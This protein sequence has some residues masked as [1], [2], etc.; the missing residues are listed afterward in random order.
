MQDR[1]VRFEE[2]MH[3]TGLARSTVYSYMRKGIFPK[4]KGGLD[5]VAAWRESE[6]QSW[7]ATD[8]W[9]EEKNQ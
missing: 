7:I 6:I 9:S 2:V 4:Q 5:S 3:L 1:L 8:N